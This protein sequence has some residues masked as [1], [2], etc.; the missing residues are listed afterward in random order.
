MHDE[1]MIRM[2]PRIHAVELVIRYEDGRINEIKGGFLQLIDVGDKAVDPRD[3]PIVFDADCD[4]AAMGVGE[5]DNRSRK[6][7]GFDSRG[8]P[9][10]VLEFLR[11]SHPFNRVFYHGQLLSHFYFNTTDTN[12]TAILEKIAKNR[13]ENRYTENRLLPNLFDSDELITNFGRDGGI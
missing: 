7:L 6:I 1:D 4:V 9:V 10:K 12:S 2:V 3:F 8:F 13:T 5:G 11:G